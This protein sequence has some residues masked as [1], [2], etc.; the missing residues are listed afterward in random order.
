MTQYVRE[1]LALENRG[2][3]LSELRTCIL[4]EP[5]FG[6]RLNRNPRSF[7]GLIKRLVSRGEIIV[8]DERLF[9]ADEMREAICIRFVRFE[10]IRRKQGRRY[11]CECPNVEG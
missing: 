5:W 11:Q 9:A 6:P 4:N 7:G 2:W 8:R 1:R 10:I 3:S